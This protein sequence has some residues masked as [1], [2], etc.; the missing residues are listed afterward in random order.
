MNDENILE[1]SN[2]EAEPQAETQAEPEQADHERPSEPE[3]DY[4]AQ[5]EKY[6]K[7]LERVSKAQQRKAD[8]T[9]ESSSV[10]VTEIAR[11]TAQE[12]LEGFRRE[13]TQ[14]IFEEELSAMS[15]NEDERELVKLVY[16]Q[17]LKPSGF[18][19]GSIRAD[20]QEAL[21]IANRPKFEAQLREKTEATIKRQTAQ[22]KQM[23]ESGTSSSS[24]RLPPED[25]G[26]S[27]AD[28]EFV[29]K[30]KQ[31]GQRLLGR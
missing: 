2:E 21:L 3:V 13:Q 5:A 11:Q 23:S 28:R 4:K 26:L 7:A 19:R 25:D 17:K 12:V 30:F 22:A 31:A 10:D 18:D 29:A 24:G 27:S 9:G 8:D 16:E 1:S 20:L 14:S 15:S 6:R